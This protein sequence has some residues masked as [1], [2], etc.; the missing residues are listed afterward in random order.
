MLNEIDETPSNRK[1]NII[2]NFDG[3]TGKNCAKKNSVLSQ[4]ADNPYR[5]L[6]RSGKTMEY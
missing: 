3:L 6:I 5:I 1:S 2:I 4:I